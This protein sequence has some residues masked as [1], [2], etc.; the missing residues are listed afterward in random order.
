ML[1]SKFADQTKYRKNKIGE[2][3][4]KLMHVQKTNGATHV[5]TKLIKL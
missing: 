1:F 3:C 2:F 4:L 5:A